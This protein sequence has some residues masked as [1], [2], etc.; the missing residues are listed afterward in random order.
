MPSGRL[1]VSPTAAIG[2]DIGCA[3]QGNNPTFTQWPTTDRIMRLTDLVVANL[4]A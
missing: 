4:P 2:R 1:S 3:Q